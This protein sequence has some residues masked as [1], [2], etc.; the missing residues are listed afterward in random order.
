[1]P[2]QMGFGVK[3]GSEAIVHAVR[4][5]L[6]DQD[7]E[8]IVKIDV[9]NAS[10]SAA[11]DI[12]LQKVKTSKQKHHFYQFNSSINVMLRKLTYVSETTL[13]CQKLNAS[14]VIQQDPAFP[15]YK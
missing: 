3:G 10:N 11:R 8:I 7:A 13:L 12:M 6:N 9:S 14:K 5:F 2:Y 15:G 4:T 1:M